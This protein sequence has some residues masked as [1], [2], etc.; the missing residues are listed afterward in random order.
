MD[1][2]NVIVARFQVPELTEGHW[3][4]INTTRDA[5]PSA[6]LVIVLGTTERPNKRNPLTYEMRRDMVQD[7]VYVDLVLPHADCPGNDAQWSWNLDHLLRLVFLGA[8]IELYCGN[9]G[10]WPHYE[11]GFKVN[12]IA[13]HTDFLRGTSVREEIGK[14]TLNCANFRQ[15]V[16]WAVQNYCGTKGWS[17]YEV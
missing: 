6:K 8:D 4:L 3:H 12:R 17:D 1:K 16:I 13:D 9:D 15:G 11:G 5:R 10:F 7:H 2:V 14:T